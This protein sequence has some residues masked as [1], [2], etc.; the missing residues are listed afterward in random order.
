[1]WGFVIKFIMAGT[2]TFLAFYVYFEPL[3]EGALLENLAFLIINISLIDALM[4]I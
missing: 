4:F 2:Y 3:E 1:M